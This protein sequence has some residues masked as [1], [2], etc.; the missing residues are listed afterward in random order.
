MTADL[1][2]S[3][4]NDNLMVVTSERSGQNR[5][6]TD[7]TVLKDLLKSTNRRKRRNISN[8]MSTNTNKQNTRMDRERHSCS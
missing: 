6:V 8:K 4:L 5:R 2:P 3:R 1:V 7:A